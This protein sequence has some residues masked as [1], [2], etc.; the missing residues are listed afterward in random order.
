ML[1]NMNEK[2]SRIISYIVF[3]SALLIILLNLISLI[4]PSLLI[5]S[6]LGSKSNENSFE[7]GAWALTFFS[8]N[9]S[10]LVFGVLYHR[11]IL[12]IKILKSKKI[13]DGY[14]GTFEI[15]EAKL[16]NHAR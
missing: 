9:I 7:I 6:I 13:W 16:D 11:K 4:F 10:I 2:K 14:R 8:I 1:E 15:L 12:P 3:A 5:T